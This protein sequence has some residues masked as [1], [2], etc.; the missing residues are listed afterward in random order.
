MDRT[1]K[2]QIMG[3]VN[4]TDNSYFADSRCLAPDGRPDIEATL[5][6]VRT[7]VS[8]GADII[9]IGAC[10]TRPGAE[11]VGAE[12]EWQRLEPVLES[13]R[14]GFPHLRISIDTYWASV[15]EKVFDKF[16]DFIVNDISAGEDDPQMLP[17]V[18]RLG[19]TYVAMH[20]RGNPLTM[21]SLTDYPDSDIEGASPVTAAVRKYFIEFADKA[22][23]NG[24]HDW[25]LDPGFGFAK[26][27]EQNWQLMD[28]MAMVT[29]TGRPT[30]VGVSRKSMVY[31]LFGITPEEVLPATQALH[32]AA[33]ERGADILR[34]HD[35]AQAVQTVQIY[36]RIGIGDLT[37]ND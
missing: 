13:V 20:K 21:Q 23:K 4:I 18:G 28:E 31:R 32:L 24:I 36:R 17:L 12:V 5:T 7:M 25:I 34:V 33:L 6:R 8:E 29:Q 11:A 9:D 37:H 22:E 15:V 10:S 26:T 19:L 16:G 2:I 35:V 14:K 30:L 3:I 1:R 27:V